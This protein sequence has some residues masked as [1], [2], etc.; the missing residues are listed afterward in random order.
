MIRVMVAISLLLFI[1]CQKDL[2][3][4]L[5]VGKHIPADAKLFEAD[6]T[7]ARFMVARSLSGSVTGVYYVTAIHDTITNVHLEYRY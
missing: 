5:Q 2:T 1:G 3:Q 6:S 7:H 4:E